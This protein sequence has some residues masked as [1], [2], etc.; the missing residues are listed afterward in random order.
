MSLIL[1]S[2]ISV[3]L[4]LPDYKPSEIPSQYWTSENFFRVIQLYEHVRHEL[5][6]VKLHYLE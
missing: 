1:Q 3:I 2:T 5:P 6:F 4:Q